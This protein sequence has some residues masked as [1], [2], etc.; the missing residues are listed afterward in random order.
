MRLKT[1]HLQVFMTPVEKD[2]LRELAAADGRSM[3]SLLRKLVTMYAAQNEE[4]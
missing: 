2:L 1:V 4:K 3:A